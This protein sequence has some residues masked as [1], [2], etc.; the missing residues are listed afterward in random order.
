MKNKISILS[1]GLDSTILTYKLVA[2]FGKDRVIALSFNYGQKHSVELEKA[3]QT[4]H[5]LGIRHKVID[6]SFI[7]EIIAPVSAL[8]SGSS[9]QTPKISEVLGDPQPPTY[10]PFR[11]ML[12]SSMAFTFAES[13]NAD[14][15]YAGFQAVDLYGY[16]DT[17]E[18]FVENMNSVTKLNRQNQIQL[19]APFIDWTKKD[20]IILGKELSVPFEDCW[21]CYNPQDVEGVLH[22]CGECATC[23]ERIQNFA[24]AGI[25]DLVPYAKN[26]PW[27]DLF[28]EYV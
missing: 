2:E 3:K 19:V 15:V 22:S 9:I 23:A 6:I 24:K 26:I 14:E 11:N 5:K 28:S 8:A 4:C 12:M 21:S 27:E 25:P 16:W 20:E 13:N 1:G 17:S 7:G 10:V 18:F